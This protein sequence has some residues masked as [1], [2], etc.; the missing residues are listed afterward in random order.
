MN[1]PR[2]VPPSDRPAAGARVPALAVSVT[3]VI[4]GLALTMVGYGINGWLVLG[5]ALSAGAAWAPQSLLGWAL[6]LFVAAGELTRHNTLGWRALVL[7]AGIHLVHILAMFTLE[8]PRRSWVHPAVFVA[9]LRRFI[10]IQ[11]PVQ[12]L[13]V[14]ALLLLAPSAAGH[15]P[16]TAGAI[17]VVGAAA[18]VGLALVLLRARPTGDA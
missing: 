1:L 16:L 11:V 8:L 6:I 9:P 13:A 2:L 3:L 7:V 18:F 5:A 12:A 17:S 14:V 10:A 4:V 15:R